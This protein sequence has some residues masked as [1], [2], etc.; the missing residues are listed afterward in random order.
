MYECKLK[1]MKRG[2][3]TALW[4]IAAVA[5]VSVTEF[6]V[7]AFYGPFHLPLSLGRND[8][9]M[10]EFN[11]GGNAAHFHAPDSPFSSA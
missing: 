8:G 1:P 7:T 2:T 11:G 3:I 5:V 9:W 6:G 10:I 4:T